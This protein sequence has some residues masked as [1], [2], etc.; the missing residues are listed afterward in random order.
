M[1]FKI[2]ILLAPSR[3]LLCSDCTRTC[4]GGSSFRAVSCVSFLGYALLDSNCPG[5]SSIA[6]RAECNTAPCFGNASFDISGWGACSA[7]CK[8][9][10]SSEPV[11]S[12]TI[13]CIDS[14]G[15]PIEASRC[16]ISGAAPP[17]TVRPCNIG[18]CLTSSPVA[19]FAMVAE[20]TPCTAILDRLGKCCNTTVCVHLHPT[21]TSIR[22]FT[23]LP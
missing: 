8:L 22:F 1:G 12:R 18:P 19:P 5:I 3:R 7:S 21:A 20:S 6:A 23:S 9:N 15:L 4:G 13:V 14:S 10:V 17:S 11:T 2:P 16:H